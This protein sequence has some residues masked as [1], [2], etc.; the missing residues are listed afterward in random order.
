MSTNDTTTPGPA[1]ITGGSGALGSAIAAALLER[2]SSVALVA[3]DADRL[4]V[5]ARRLAHLGRVATVA[6]DVT[7]PDDR[8]RIVDQA[9]AALGSVGV[10]VNNAG[11]EQLGRL[12]QHTTDDVASLAAINL[13]APIELAR[14]TLPALRAS[15]GHIVNISTMAAKTPMTPM[16]VYAGTKAGLGYFSRLLRLELAAEGVGVSVVY[17]G[18]IADDGMFA[19]MQSETGV[20]LPK[21]MP[22]SSPEWVAARV[23][24]AI[25]GDR[26][27]V[28]AAPGGAVMAR[29]PRLAGRMLRSM[30][31]PETFAEMAEV[32]LAARSTP[33]GTG[34]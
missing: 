33:A 32:R 24:R 22:L 29:H 16:S 17:P 14:L 27:E 3:R 9:T 11:A 21:R 20:S 2:G 19:R 28:H 31:I 34:S 18:A 5:T 13:V 7:D 6:G 10:L 23:V 25:T 1:I 4:A 12:E 8:H 30:G 15:G 26:A